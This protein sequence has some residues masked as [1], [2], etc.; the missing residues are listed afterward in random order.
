MKFFRKYIELELFGIIVLSSLSPKPNPPIPTD[1]E[2]AL[3]LL[4]YQVEDVV[5]SGMI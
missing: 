5:A 2:L 1:Q 3:K 4:S